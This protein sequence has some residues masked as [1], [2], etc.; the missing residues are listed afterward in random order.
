MHKYREVAKKLLLSKKK[1]LKT[2]KM[3]QYCIRETIILK[4]II[5]K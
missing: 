3:H 2:K 5:K 1:I 4:V